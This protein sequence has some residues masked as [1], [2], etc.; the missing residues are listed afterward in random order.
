MGW[1]AVFCHRTQHKEHAV[2]DI[3][4][5]PPR[6]LI[7]I[8][9]GLIKTMGHV[10]TGLGELVHHI[11]F[12]SFTLDERDGNPEPR[13]WFNNE[14]QSSI[15]AVGLANQGLRSFLEELKQN[16]EFYLHLI[17]Q[18]CKIRLSLAPLKTGDL[19]KM[20]KVLWEY[21]EIVL[22]LISEVEVNASCPNHRND[23]GV[24]HKVL[25]H[26]PM[27]LG[28]L[29]AEGK[30]LPIPKAIKL[31]ARMTYR[32]LSGAVELCVHYGYVTIVNHNTLLGSS[33]IGG[34]RRLSMDQGG[35]GGALILDDAVRQTAELRE[36]CDSIRSPQPAP[37]IIGC[38]GVMSVDGARKHLSGGADV[39]QVATYFAEY[40]A[41]GIRDLVAELA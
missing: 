2:N 3:D 21:R 41:I 29:M 13:Y 1:N 18:G 31:T 36:I 40:G 15:N 37:K 4:F 23:A 38:G 11:T 16:K 35:I 8:A 27:A 12:G 26:D 39:V 10:P 24:L 6:R 17:A 7:G 14:T 34:E 25:A 28:I 32:A 9:A 19:E 30:D 33:T 5:A 20:V 22:L